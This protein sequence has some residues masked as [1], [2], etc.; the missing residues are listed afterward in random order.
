MLESLFV[1]G[2]SVLTLFLLMS[3]GFLFGRMGL[4]SGDTLSQVSRILLYVVT[5][6]IMLTSFEVE[7][8]AENQAQLLAALAAMAGLYVA[9]MLLSQVLFPRAGEAHQGIMR[10]AA[11]YGN[12]GFMGLP[13]IQSVMGDEAMMVAVVGLG[14]FNAVSWTQGRALIGGRKELS[15]KKLALN[16]GIIGFVGGLLLYFTGWRFPGPLD[17]AVAYLGSLNTP[18]AM[19]VIGGQMAQADL[20]KVFST[21]KLYLVSAVKLLAVP[22]LTALALLPF[23]PDPVIYVAAVI[24]AGCPTAGATSLFAQSMGKDAALAAQQVTLSTLLC[25]VTLPVM[26]SLAQLLI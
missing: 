4:L 25:V 11:V 3:V 12:A 9:Y 18:L 20:V 15:L 17:S 10:F 14:I 13:L 22:M 8:T 16:P 19:V 2:G 21:R 1:V 5:P 7:R 23:R 24:L 6:C 26:A